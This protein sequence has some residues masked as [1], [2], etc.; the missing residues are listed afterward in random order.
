M[1]YV[2]LSGRIVR[3]PEFKFTAS[4]VGLL[5]MTVV[6]D[7]TPRWD[8]EKDAHVARQN[9]VSVQFWGSMAEKLAEDGVNKGME[10]M[11]EGE[12]DQSEYE[13]RDGKKES[14]TRVRGWLLALLS[15]AVESVGGRDDMVAS[16]EPPF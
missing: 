11:I 13:N 16:E 7:S 15:P 14:K 8:R 5:Q 2:K 1:N 9:F 4:G 3:E 12:I 6:V 10:V